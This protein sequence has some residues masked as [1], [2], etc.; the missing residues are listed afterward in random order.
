MWV[1]IKRDE[2]RTLV[3]IEHGEVHYGSASGKSEHYNI[4]HELD[5][6]FLDLHSKWGL[7][8]FDCGFMVSKS[9]DLTRRTLTAKNKSYDLTGGTSHTIVD[10]VTKKQREAGMV[11]TLVHDGPLRLEV[12]LYDLPE[13]DEL[14]YML[15]HGI[16]GQTRRDLMQTLTYDA[17]AWL[18]TTE[19]SLISKPEHLDYLF[20][21]AVA[22]GHEGMMAKRLGYKWV[23]GRTSDWMKVKP[24]AERDGVI[25]GWN[26]GTVGTEFEGMVGS[27]IV[28]FI[29]GSKASCSGMDL[30]TRRD[31]TEHFVSKYL[32]KIAEVH[33][34]QRDSQ[35]GYRHPNFYR[36]HPEK[37]D[38][39]QCD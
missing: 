21:E 13:K 39:A 38:I 2:F 3:T 4:P 25:I 35:G 36:L 9:F 20:D 12:F 7:N 10:K 34:M 18:R 37:T 1:D 16:C 28:E 15:P 11:D 26:P 31:M 29:D 17:I 24:E 30:P 5:T 8:V 19:G 22:E 32:G 23:A 6:V 14:P 27:V 33:Y